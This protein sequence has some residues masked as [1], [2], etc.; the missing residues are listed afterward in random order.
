MGK[1]A[2]VFSGQ[3][4][5]YTGMGKSLWE[6]SPAARAVFEAADSQRPGTSQ[7]CFTAPVEEL[8][9]TKNTQPCV[10]CVDLAA[11]R[12]LEEAG[13]KADYVAGF[14]LGE[15]AAL[16]FAGVFPG[17]E[18]FGF[19]CKRAEAMQKAAEENP[20]A[21]AAVL[22]LKNEQV[23]AIC[24]EFEQVWPVNYN[25]PGQLV[26]AGEKGQIEAFCKKVAEAG[27]RAVPLAVSGGFHSPFMESAGEELRTVLAGMEAPGAPGAGVRQPERQALHPGGGQG[28][29]GPAGEEP[30]AVAGDH[31]GPGRPGGGHLFGVRPRQ[32]FVRAHPQDGEG[33]EGLSGG[34][35]G[36]PLRRGGGRE[37][38]RVRQ[39]R[40]RGGVILERM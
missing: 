25:C 4:A 21:M 40:P 17:E 2:F 3:G 13:V 10:Y 37:S 18:G 36:D 1:V 11:A 9:V 32:D 38:G 29:F 14:S 35:R 5:Q 19:V 24:Q 39:Y 34:G 28:A 23:E 12:A 31:R 6:K 20:G 30:G 15:V 16:S 26:V 27:G 22:K 8:S 7:Q 33:R